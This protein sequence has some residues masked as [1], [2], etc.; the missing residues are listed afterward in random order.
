MH[1]RIK[2]LAIFATLFI[3]TT[4]G[5]RAQDIYS[6]DFTTL[7]NWTVVTGCSPGYRW[8]ADA[9]PKDRYCGSPAFMSAPASLNFNNGSDVGGWGIH[10]GADYTCGSVTSP[11]ID[12]GVAV[13][14]AELSFWVSVDMEQFCGYDELRLI[15]SPAGGG[16]AF[17]DE[18]IK[19][20]LTLC[21]WQE[22]TMPLD[23]QWGNVEIGFSFDTLDD[24]V[25]IGSGPFID[26]LRVSS[27]EPCLAPTNFCSTTANSS[28]N[29]AYMAYAGSTSV[30]ANDFEIRALDCPPG[31]PGLFFYG[32]TQ[33]STPYGD[34]TLC[35]GAGGVGYFRVQPT[36]VT[37]A[38]GEATRGIDNTTG[39]YASGLSQIAPGVTWNFQFWFR[40]PQG[41]PAGFS[42]SD[43]LEVT[44]CP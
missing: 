41:G 42:F 4:D 23:V 40:D 3:L 17:F 16:T 5:A 11:P 31:K 28:G 10:G 43:G 33:V 30:A 13:A 26:D 8:K 34:G 9:T 24:W 29:S 25:N 37:S 27:V 18:C 21:S 14:G 15:I 6:T 12:L 19:D 44:F 38:S 22:F 20:E 2:S 35:A 39:I 32:P 36:I 7:D 1:V